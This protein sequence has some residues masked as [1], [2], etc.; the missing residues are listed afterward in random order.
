MAGKQKA[1]EALAAKK[2]GARF[3]KECRD[4]FGVEQDRDDID[5]AGRSQVLGANRGA[6]WFVA[7]DV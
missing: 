4:L 1:Q 7:N 3:D 5:K 6:T 2:E